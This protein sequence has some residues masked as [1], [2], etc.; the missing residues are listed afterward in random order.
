LPSAVA[1]AHYDA[2]DRLELSPLELLEIG[3]E[4]GKHAQGTVFSVAVTV[5][6]G[7]GV[8]PWTIVTRYPGIWARIW[9]GGGVSIIKTGPKDAR[10]EIAGWPC[11]RSTYCRIAMRG[12]LRG[13][14]ELF[15]TRAYVKEIPRLCTPLTLGYHVEWA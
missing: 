12:V 8:T 10:L 6:K 13:L 9:I 7:A 2:C 14:T 4:V 5:A 15:A 1:E 3:A 11:A